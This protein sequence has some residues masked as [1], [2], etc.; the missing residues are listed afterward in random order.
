MP[1]KFA[2]TFFLWHRCWQEFCK[3]EK[4]KPLFLCTLEFLGQWFVNLDILDFIY[5]F[6]E[7]STI[8]WLSQLHEV[9]PLVW[10]SQLH[11]VSHFFH[12]LNFT[13]Y[14]PLFDYLNFMKYPPC[15]IISILLHVSIPLVWLY[16][17]QFHK[18]C[19]LVLLSQSHEVSPLF[20]YLN[21]TKYP[22]CLIISI[23]R[24]TPLVWL[25]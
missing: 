23:S 3:N 1:S 2:R 14:P 13:K 5:Q 10:L 16:M 17:Y 11:E 4:K 7:V 24:S 9:C 18:V 20:Y 21:L 6:H 8:V 22:P 12:Y 15:L 25:V 19:P